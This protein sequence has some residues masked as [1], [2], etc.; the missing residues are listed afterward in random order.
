MVDSVAR[1]IFCSIDIHAFFIFLPL[2]RNFVNFKRL[3]LHLFNLS[4]EWLVFYNFC[5]QNFTFLHY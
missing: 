2:F 5:S 3:Y 4:F 1:T